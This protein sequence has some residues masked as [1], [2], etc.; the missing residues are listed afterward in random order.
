MTVIGGGLAGMAASLHLAKAGFTVV[1]IEPEAEP[2]K[3]V[4][5]SL[6]WSAPEL[7]RVLGLPMERLIEDGVA[8]YKRHVTVKLG[9][10]CDRHYVPSNW[11]ARPPFNV[12]L[13]TMHVDR[14][15]LHEA[16]HA[17]VVS[18]EVQI[19]HDRVVRVESVGEWASS[20]TTAQGARFLVPLVH[21]RFGCWH[22]PIRAG[23]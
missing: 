1:C 5:E 12:E 15:R 18:N 14:L 22:K 8:T 13:R 23:V 4:G 2:T 3:L 6:D 7:L 21:R 11:V 10:G 16:L 9:D 20:V 17:I 19:V